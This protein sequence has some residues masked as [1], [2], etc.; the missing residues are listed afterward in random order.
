M[1]TMLKKEFRE[2]WRSKKLI[3]TFIILAVLAMTSIVL[4][5]YEPQLINA[6]LT[7]QGTELPESFLEYLAIPPDVSQASADLFGNLANIMIWIIILTTATAVNAEYI[8]GTY[9]L[10]LNTK[11][12]GLILTKF[13]ARVCVNIGAILVAS[14]LAVVYIEVL[15]APEKLVG[16]LESLIVL[17]VYAVFTTAYALLFSAVCKTVLKSIG[18]SIVF[19]MVLQMVSSFPG[20]GGYLPAGITTHISAFLSG[21]NS[22]VYAAYLVITIA[23]TILCLVLG[24]IAVNKHRD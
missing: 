1:I 6:L 10:Y 24:T 17:C 23:L 11:K 14:A 2:L 19:C 9:A 3:V 16:F 15:F 13:A 8:N 18:L 22:T 4:S 20:I 12:S 7:A 5:K 21:T